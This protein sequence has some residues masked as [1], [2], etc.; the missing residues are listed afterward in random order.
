MNG[1]EG[2]IGISPAVGIADSGLY[3]TE[4]PGI[5]LNNLNKIA[6][7]PDKEDF[8]D[9]FKV[10]EKR[11][12]L[13]FHAAFTAQLNICWHVCEPTVTECLMDHYKQKLAAA[14]WWL[15]GAEIMIERQA[16]DRLNRFTTIDLEKA[17][18]MQAFFEARA[19]HEL[20]NAVKSIDP[21][22]CT[23]STVERKS[24]ITFIEVLP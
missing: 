4:L 10:C 5:N 17:G 18:E 23:E 6:D 1:W 9:V 8:Q 12:L 16:S 22:V 7:R 11:V 20:K 3:V 19:A 13:S 24:F 21:G 15:I 14:L 2:Y